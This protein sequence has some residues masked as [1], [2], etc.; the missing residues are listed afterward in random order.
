MNK[1]MSV[2]TILMLSL[3]LLVTCFIIPPVS[4]IDRT[5]KFG[6]LISAWTCDVKGITP[7]QVKAIIDEAY[8]RKTITFTAIK[9]TYGYDPANGAQYTADRIHVW[10]DYFSTYYSTIYVASRSVFHIGRKLTLAEIND[11]YSRVATVLNAHSKVK[12]FIG[13]EEPEAKQVD[14]Y[15]GAPLGN[16][17]A[18]SSWADMK[19][20]IITLHD[21][22][23]AY[24][25]LPFA[26]ESIPPVKQEGEN[27]VNLDCWFFQTVNAAEYWAWIDAYQDIFAIDEWRFHDGVTL[28]HQH[29]GQYN[30]IH[31]MRY[32][33]IGETFNLDYTQTENL[34]DAFGVDCNY[35]FWW[36]VNGVEPVP[37]ENPAA[38]EP[39]I[40]WRGGFRDHCWA[41]LNKKL[42][43]TCWG[44][45]LCSLNTYSQN[46]NDRAIF[47]KHPSFISS[48]SLDEE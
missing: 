44:T 26:Y 46:I 40:Y 41:Y 9:I 36:A 13:E 28:W 10:V 37:S 47:E 16:N 24:S 43:G 11:Y 21:R 22:W 32:L 5:Q 34:I 38:P 17:L 42:W 1:K 27:L 39:Y 2:V 30:Q 45:Y 14:P 4:A 20:Y 31:P 25:S 48:G 3:I 6:L 23:H 12:C 19:A 35:F 18:Y 29:V 8:T 33:F 7:A 15:T